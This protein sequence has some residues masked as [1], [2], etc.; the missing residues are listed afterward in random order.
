MVKIITVSPG[1]I[2]LMEFLN[3]Y[4][5]SPTQLSKLLH[6]STSTIYRVV[7]EQK[8]ITV[9]LAM[10]LSKFFDNSVEFWINLQR[11]WDVQKLNRSMVRELARIKPLADLQREAAQLST[12]PNVILLKAPRKSYRGVVKSV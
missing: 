8:P 6:V 11:D 10:R 4:H 7:Y 9:N 5:I 1:E 2:L 12:I 3:P